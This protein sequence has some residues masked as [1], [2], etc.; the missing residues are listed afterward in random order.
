[1]FGPIAFMIIVVAALLII[2][3][4]RGTGK[5]LLGFGF[6]LIFLVPMF[7]AFF[8][9]TAG[10]V[11]DLSG[12]FVLFGIVFIIWIVIRNRRYKRASARTPQNPPPSSK[13]RVE[14][15]FL[16]SSLSDKHEGGK[17]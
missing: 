14:I 9:Q 4:F 7:Q 10:S 2:L 3:G 12:V 17:F 13:K 6:G 16:N 15:P 8:T 1:M 5:R 11:S